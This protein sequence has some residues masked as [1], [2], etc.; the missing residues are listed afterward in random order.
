[1]KNI[2]VI[3]D[4]NSLRVTIKAFLRKHGYEVLEAE[5]G[6]KGL[7]LARAQLPDLVLSD[8]NM[9]G[10]DGFGVL[11]GLRSHL[12]TSAI[13]FILMTGV[14]ES[15]SARL[16]MEWGADDYLA[17]PFEMQTLLPA[18]CKWLAISTCPSGRSNK[19]S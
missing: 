4:D 6:E 12:A 14:P 1:M 10:L 17:K 13:P 9:A 18:C 7:E 2:L 3:D 5:N 15:P 16:G 8:V 19:P 11:K